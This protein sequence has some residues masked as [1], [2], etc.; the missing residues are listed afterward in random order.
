VVRILGGYRN[1]QDD[2]RAVRSRTGLVSIAPSDK[3]PRGEWILD[4]VEGGR[5]Y[6]ARDGDAKRQQ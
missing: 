2:A 5:E 6:A 4:T 3:H 1:W